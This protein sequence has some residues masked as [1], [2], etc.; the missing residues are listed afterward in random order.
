MTG[1]HDRVQARPR[2]SMRRATAARSET[3]SLPIPALPGEGAFAASGTNVAVSGANHVWIGTT[4]SRVLRSA[5][6]GRSWAISQTPIAT[7][8]ATGIFSIAFKDPSHGVVVGGNYEQESTPG[9]HAAVTSDGG[10]TWTLS[11]A[12]ASGFRSVAAWASATGRLLAIG[13][14]GAD[15]SG[16]DGRTWTAVSMKVPAGT[17]AGFDTASFAPGSGV[18]WAIGAGGRISKLT[19]Q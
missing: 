19:M 15:W 11:K 12:P 6:G 3:C 4:A 14:A 18:G 8:N 1:R 2:A 17:P 7:A 16:D 10:A 13:P 9:N 5:D